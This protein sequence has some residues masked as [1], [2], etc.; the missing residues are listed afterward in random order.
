MH[1]TNFVWHSP[2]A[3]MAGRRTQFAVKHHHSL[4]CKECVQSSFQ[5]KFSLWILTQI[6]TVLTSDISKHKHIYKIAVHNK[7]LKVNLWHTSNIPK[8][9][10]TTTNWRSPVPTHSTIWDPLRDSAT[11]TRRSPITSSTLW[12]HVWSCIPSNRPSVATTS[13]WYH[14]IWSI[15]TS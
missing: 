4:T 11:S 15:S 10:C 6:L 7:Y 12:P 8:L 5:H 9:L 14:P 1:K 3:C 13:T 2:V